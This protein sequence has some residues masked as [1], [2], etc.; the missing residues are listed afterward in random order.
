M[1]VAL[2]RSAWIYPKTMIEMRFLSFPII[3]RRQA[4][5]W[6]TMLMCGRGNVIS[7][8]PFLA[9]ITFGRSAR[10]IS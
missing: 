10:Q 1:T 6:Q 4:D 7:T 3:S 9:I 2:A 5:M 8:W